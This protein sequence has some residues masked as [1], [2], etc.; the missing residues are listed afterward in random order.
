V[1]TSTIA[2]TRS[3]FMTCKTPKMSFAF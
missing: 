1:P 3:F 2:S